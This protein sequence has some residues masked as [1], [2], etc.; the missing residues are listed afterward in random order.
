MAR[1]FSDRLEQAKSVE[2]ISAMVGMVHD[3][4]SPISTV[5]QAQE[6]F[7]Q[8]FSAEIL[9]TKLGAVEFEDSYGPLTLHALWGPSVDTGSPWRRRSEQSRWG[10]NCICSTP[11]TN[12]PAACLAKPR[13]S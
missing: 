1:S 6:F 11:V 4:G 5:Q 8:G 10:I 3:A 13:H 2:G 9:L 12:R 7:A